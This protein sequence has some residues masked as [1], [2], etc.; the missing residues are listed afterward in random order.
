VVKAN[1]S[2]RLLYVTV[3]ALV[4]A[5]TINAGADLGAIA[6]GINLMAPVPIRVLILPV[7]AAV[8]ALQVLGSY[9]LIAN[10]FKWLSL[11]LLAYVLSAFFSK[12]D[13]GEVLRGTFLP[14]LAWDKNFLAMTVGILGTTISPYMFFWQSNQ[15]VEEEI[16]EAG[17]DPG[18]VTVRGD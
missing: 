5:N 16:A 8:I 2:K 14:R 7:A 13:L 9:R 11:A 1:Y 3:I 10:I 18:R 12:P 17:R 15:E 4:A 6:A